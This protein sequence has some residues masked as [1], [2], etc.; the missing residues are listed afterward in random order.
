M[1]GELILLYYGADYV[2]RGFKGGQSKSIAEGYNQTINI[3][4]DYLGISSDVLKDATQEAYTG[5]KLQALAKAARGII[6]PAK[7]DANAK[8]SLAGGKEF[9][10][11]SIKD[12]PGDIDFEYE[13]DVEI[14]EP[15]QRVRISVRATDLDKNKSG[16]AGVVKKISDARLKIE[17]YPTID[18]K[19]LYGNKSACLCQGDNQRKK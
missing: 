18:L 14:Q 11:Q 2:F 15:Y 8:L 16:W 5:K 6:A 19:K 9:N 7:N 1:N 12:F 17:V 3:A 4:G 10:A 13:D